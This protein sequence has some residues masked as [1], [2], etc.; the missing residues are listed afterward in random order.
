MTDDA[1]ALHS[2]NAQS[3]LAKE[4][5]LL[6]LADAQKV[7]ASKATEFEQQLSDERQAYSG[8]LSSFEQ[9]SR[10]HEEVDA[11]LKFANAQEI[12]YKQQLDALR[13]QVAAMRA[14]KP[15]PASDPSSAIRGSFNVLGEKK[16]HFTIICFI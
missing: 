6:Q 11:R 13:A 16:T 8:L 14:P 2:R 9:L 10:E 1:A 7:A 5:L 3:A 12:D 4:E 15:K